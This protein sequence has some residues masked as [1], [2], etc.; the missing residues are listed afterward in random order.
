[1]R[2]PLVKLLSC[3]LITLFIC[4]PIALAQSSA[5]SVDSTLTGCSDPITWT[6]GSIDSR[7]DITPSALK[8]IM[9]DVENL[10]SD[11][12]DQN[13]IQYSDSG[14]VAINLIYS[15]NQK[16]TD[17]EQQLSEQINKMR[18]KYYSMRMDY[19]RESVEFQ[20]KL[21]DYN[22]TF[23]AYAK[24]VNEYNL[25]LSRLANTGIL[26]RDEDEKLKNLKKEM[27]FLEQKLDPKEEE[28]T[29]E[30]RK[31]HRMSDDLNDYADEVN[32]YVYQYR[33][34]FSQA[35]TFYQGFYTDVGNRKKINIFQFDNTDKLKLVLAHEIGQALGL[36]HTDNPVS[37]MNYNMQLQLDQRLKL[38][39]EDIS[40]IQN[41][42]NHSQ[43]NM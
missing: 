28:L 42:C 13:L 21:A 25:R 27:E 33:N 9:T 23:T 30:E 20:R 22:Q 24:K 3:F 38:S 41:K 35:R 31:L 34:R 19:Q 14:E 7:F 36:S 12:L 5:S 11:A 37:I 17:N 1:M 43:A 39:D 16:F 18:K 2:N 15:E 26:S 10:W 8:G 32:E 29:K 40:A 6:V 4:A